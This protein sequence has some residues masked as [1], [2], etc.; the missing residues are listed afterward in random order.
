[1]PSLVSDTFARKSTLRAGGPVPPQA[2][3]PPYPVCFQFKTETAKD[4]SYFFSK[5]CNAADPDYIDIDA[6]SQDYWYYKLNK[7]QL[8]ITITEYAK[9]WG[10]FDMCVS[11]F[12]IQI[13]KP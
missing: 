1:V 10:V 9:D 5:K 11:S 6:V 8:P 2:G 13:P 3:K 4:T 7:M 12:T